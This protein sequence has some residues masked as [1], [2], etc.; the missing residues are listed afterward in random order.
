MT[1]FADE[2]PDHEPKDRDL[3]IEQ[4]RKSFHALLPV[5]SC[6]YCNSPLNR[7]ILFCDS[8]CQADWE[9]EQQARLRNGS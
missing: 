9:D 7:D 3:S 2:S 6:H 5:G 8:L 4:H 1:D